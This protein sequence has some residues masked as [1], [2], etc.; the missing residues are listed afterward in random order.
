MSRRPPHPSVL[1]LIM[2]DMGRRWGFCGD[3]QARSPHVDT[4]A[5]SSVVFESHFSQWPLCGPSRANIFSGCR[6]L[7]TGRFNNQPFFPGFRARIGQDFHTLPE[8]FRRHGYRTL[9][10]GVVY[11]DVDDPLSWSEPFW[12]PSPPQ[13]E[14][15]WLRLAQAASPNPWLSPESHALI[16]ER[17]RR[18]RDAGVP[19]GQLGTPDGLRRFRGPAVEA[20][21]GTEEAYFDGQ[22]TARVL[23]W[24]ETL[25]EAEPFFLTVGFTA[26]HLPFNSPRRFWGLYNRRDLRLLGFRLP[27]YGAPDWAEGDSEPVQYYTQDGYDLPWHASTE[28]S[29]ELLHGHYAALSYMDALVGRL[30]Q[31]LKDREL[32]ENTVVVL[33]SDHGFHD[34]EHGYWGK[35]N[36]WERSLAVPLLI[37]LPGAARGG[38]RITALTEHV[39]LY[40]TLCQLCG[41]SQPGYLEGSGL[42]SLIGEPGRPWKRAVLAHRRPMW[43]DRLKVYGI[44]HSVRTAHYRYTEY[45]DHHGGVLHRELFD[46][47]E[48]PEERANRAASVES[49][50]LA[51]ELARLIR[52]GWPALRPPGE[53]E[54]T[55]PRSS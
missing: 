23:Q 53:G 37:R 7:T 41:L 51:A 26:G 3:S 45:L 22:T 42:A 16:E 20:G 15:E 40:P 43:H 34:G 49:L 27:P 44:A 24:I 8:H 21:E 5:A 17:W 29:L 2:H 12:E 11:H 19:E 39:D 14:P 33:T 35:H 55:L 1:F 47:R 31:A 25:Q 52:A 48:D 10:A 54:G 18:L 38:T 28:Q 50:E 13:E 36:L 9:G 30:L 32:L 6:P 4:L 46:Y